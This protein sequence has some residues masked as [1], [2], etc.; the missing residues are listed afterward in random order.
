M[1]RCQEMLTLQFQTSL[2]QVQDKSKVTNPQSLTPT[3]GTQTETDIKSCRRKKRAA[4]RDCYPICQQ[5]K[6][7]VD[8]TELKME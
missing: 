3:S 6:I 7:L 2:G 8:V 4:G 1:T 5:M